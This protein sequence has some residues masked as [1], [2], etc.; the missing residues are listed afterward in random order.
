MFM[1]F[2][3]SLAKKLTKD[4]LN[5]MIDLNSNYILKNSNNQA[6]IYDP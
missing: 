5:L 6:F 1:I 2:D 4:Q 3:E